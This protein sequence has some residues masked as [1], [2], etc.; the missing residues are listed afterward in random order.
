MDKEDA[1]TWLDYH[2]HKINPTR[3]KLQA[4]VFSNNGISEP[5]SFKLN[6]H[7]L[8]LTPLPKDS[9]SQEIIE[10]FMPAFTCEVIS[11]YNAHR[12]GNNF[13]IHKCLDCILPL[14][15]WK[16]RL[17]N[18]YTQ[19]EEFHGKWI[20]SPSS[21]C[22]IFSLIRRNELS[23]PR[24]VK[25]VNAYEKASRNEDKRSEKAIK[26]R[27][28]LKEAIE[29]EAISHQYSFLSYYSI[30]ETISVDLAK[31]EDINSGNSMALEKEKFLQIEKNSQRKNISFLLIAIQNSFEIN[32]CLSLA[33][34]RNKIAHGSQSV[35]L[36]EQSF[37]LCKELAFWASENFILQINKID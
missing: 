8:T 27:K 21:S 18:N 5:V 15:G 32:E 14:V 12:G 19:W 9:Q 30:L 35:S 10:G 1:T 22:R 17:S 23:S 3:Y 26:I 34:I 31:N 28:R 24:I 33:D 25:I 36:S 13:D 4:T 6:G 37:E 11:E 7:I 16:Y 2:E 29:L 20:K